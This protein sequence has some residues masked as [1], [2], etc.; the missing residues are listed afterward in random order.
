M[1]AFS[2]AVRS[3]LKYF[4]ESQGTTGVLV[5][6]RSKAMARELSQQF[7]TRAIEKTYLAL[8]R[9][10]SGRFPVKEGLIAASLSF[11]DGRVRVQAAAAAD[12]SGAH[13]EEEPGPGVKAAR[14]AWEVL[15]SSVSPTRRVLKG[16]SPPSLKFVL[17]TGHRAVVSGAPVSTYGIETPA[18]RA[19]GA[20]FGRYVGCWVRPLETVWIA[21]CALSFQCRFLVTPCTEVQRQA[22]AFRKADFSYTLLQSPFGCVPFVSAPFFRSSSQEA[23]SPPRDIGA[24]VIASVS[25]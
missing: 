1:H 18:A 11:D 2:T 13:A 6:A 23:D 5:L 17:A 12:A 15:A 8:V 3:W 25:V 10:D 20:C 9:G 16:G 19:H 21:P 22:Q 24:R 4:F 7:R 14:T